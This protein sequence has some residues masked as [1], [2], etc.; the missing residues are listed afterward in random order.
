MYS[1]RS[2]NEATVRNT[3]DKNVFKGFFDG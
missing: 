2:Q 1:Q 3:M